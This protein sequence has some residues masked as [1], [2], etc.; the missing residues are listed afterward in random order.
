MYPIETTTKKM[1]VVGVL[2]ACGC[3]LLFSFFDNIYCQMILGV[4]LYRHGDVCALLNF[5]AVPNVPV[6]V[7]DVVDGMLHDHR[8]LLSFER[9]SFAVRPSCVRSG[10]HVVCPD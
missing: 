7:I 9:P 8:V 5:S 4:L 1:G 3:S 6:H 2:P 10:S